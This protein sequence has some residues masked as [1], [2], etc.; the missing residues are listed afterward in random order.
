MRT[1]EDFL[2]IARLIK[3]GY[4]RH[5]EGSLAATPAGQEYCRKAEN[6]FTKVQIA[7]LHRRIE[8][9]KYWVPKVGELVYT[10]TRMY[11]DHGMDDVEG[12][13]SQV[14]RV[15][16]S[17]SGGDPHCVFIEVAQHGH[18]GN[19]MQSLFRDQKELMARFG[20][21]VAYPDPDYVRA[22]GVGI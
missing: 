19:W 7:R 18:G 16:K 13:L 14:T 1:S 2:A 17:M 21:Q 8:K 9:G 20:N 11:I 3:L 4:V 12:G 5:H 15:Y 10:D 22:D 6:M